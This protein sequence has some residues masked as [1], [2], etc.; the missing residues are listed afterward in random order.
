MSPFE[1]GEKNIVFWLVLATYCN[2]ATYATYCNISEKM[3]SG[4]FRPRKSVPVSIWL[5]PLLRFFLYAALCA[6]DVVQ[7]IF[8]VGLAECAVH[9]RILVCFFTAGIT[10]FIALAWQGK[11]GGG[12]S[13]EVMFYRT[14]QKVV[15]HVAGPDGIR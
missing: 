1:D 2:N 7:K 10:G 15:Q 5:L 3:I 6:P 14:L 9:R 11:R 13:N 4:V 8:L 12:W